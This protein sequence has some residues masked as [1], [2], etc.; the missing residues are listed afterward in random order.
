M[1][2]QL[3]RREF[4]GASILASAAASLPADGHE[5]RRFLAALAPGQAPGAKGGDAAPAQVPMGRLGTLDVSRI[6]LG[7]NLIGGWAHARD[8]I[9]VSK[10]FQAYNTPERI[11]RTIELAQGH[12]INTILLNPAYLH[13]ARDFNR[14]HDQK[15][16]VISEIHLDAKTA[17]KDTIRAE[18]RRLIA[19]GA[20]TLYIQGMVGDRLLREGRVDLIGT[21][22]EAIRAAGVPAGVGSH[23]LEVTVAC[24]Q[25]R[26]PVDYYMKTFHPAA[27]WTASRPEDRK[28]WF[29]EGYHDNVWC[30]DADRT[31]DFMAGVE[32]PW[33]AFKILGAGAIHP[34][35]G[36]LYAFENGADFA[37]VGMFDFQ[38]DEDAAIA[39]KVLAR[40]SVRERRRP[41]RA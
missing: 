41:W 25:Q 37:V 19:A 12:G 2:R 36:F 11:T 5:E 10:L 26:L 34:K 35:H 32:K 17:T 9:Y 22:L 39:A 28:E 15:L 40:T 33:L 7:G 18:V 3:D 13:V 14:I 30:T 24:E 27:Y 4:L 20:H 8:L 29:Q 31:R 6:I 1:A 23:T 38:V 16:C 21:A